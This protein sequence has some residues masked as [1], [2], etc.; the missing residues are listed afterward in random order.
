MDTPLLDAQAE[1]LDTAVDCYKSVLETGHGRLMFV[2]G[3]A[4]SGRATVLRRIADRLSWEL[5]SPLIVGGQIVGNE[6]KTWS[7]PA[8]DDVRIA[9]SLEPVI[10][11]REPVQQAGQMTASGLVAAVNPWLG[12]LAAVISTAVVATDLKNRLKN[13]LASR[14]ERA[15]LPGLMLDLI[16]GESEK[17]PVVLLLADVDLASDAWL[18]LFLD[19]AAR[20]LPISLRVLL[21]VSLVGGKTPG[22]HSESEPMILRIARREVEDRRLATWCYLPPLTP[23][24][25]EQVIGPIEPKLGDAVVEATG[26]N[27]AFIL[28]L[29]DEWRKSR[30]VKRDR[31]E[32]QWKLIHGLEEQAAWALRN[33]VESR[34]RSIAGQDAAVFDRL[35]D[36]LRIGALQGPVFSA[37]SVARALVPPCDPDDLIDEF[38][39]RLIP[40][41]GQDGAVLR[42]A[43]F[44]PHTKAALYEFATRLYWML[45]KKYVAAQELPNLTHR[46]ANG[47]VETYRPYELQASRILARLYE[48]ASESELA[49]YYTAIADFQASGE[50]LSLHARALLGLSTSGWDAWNFIDFAHTL[51]ELGE[52]LFVRGYVKPAQ[53]LFERAL[54]I[55]LERLGP[56]HLESARSFNDVARTHHSLWELAIA[57]SQY[58]RALR[59]LEKVVGRDQ[60]ETAAVLDN[61]GV[62]LLDLEQ[63]A[64]AEPL[65]RRA[66]TIRQTK[67]GPRHPHTAASLHNLALYVQSQGKKEEALSLNRSALDIREKALGPEHRDTALSLSQISAIL[68]RLGQNDAAR[69]LDERALEIRKKVLGIEHPDTAQSLN[70]LGATLMLQGKKDEARPLL[71]RAMVINERLLGDHPETATSLYNF[72]GVL[73]VERDLLRA[74]ELLIRAHSIRVKT[75]GNRH[76]MSLDVER[77]IDEIDQVLR[78]DVG[79]A[80][81][82]APT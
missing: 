33:P 64:E 11:L 22:R 18:T 41:T 78:Q 20:E 23:S 29:W 24:E 81:T 80:G 9:R 1:A 70:N 8:T 34:L 44:A 72:A 71:E 82:A 68:T 4:G 52:Q 10:Y 62:L 16:R 28:Q 53:L 42:E 75:L 21:I 49:E 40:D 55:R 14:L 73:V 47:I 3:A 30:L 38:D 37:G 51:S 69:Q 56:E 74:R 7:S 79:D 15:K 6:F 13:G 48:Q 39:D 27:L 76:P 45:M 59:I 32:G 25:V 67:L 63:F 26:G 66:L 31:R 19:A 2:V 43:G 61:L 54:A 77:V 58:E 17:R 46:L 36:A 65:I 50:E 5:P 35:W 12:L 60:P 57:R